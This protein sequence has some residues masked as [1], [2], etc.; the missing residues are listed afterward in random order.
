VWAEASVHVE[1]S[2]LSHA[3]LY[4]ERHTLILMHIHG[5]SRELATPV[6]AVLICWHIDLCR[7]MVRSRECEKGAG[8]LEALMASAAVAGN[9]VVVAATTDAWEAARH[10]FARLLGRGDPD[11][12][13]TAE[14]RLE[15]THEQLTNT[16]G[17]VLE[18][19]RAAVEVQWTTRLADLLDEYPEA[20]SDLRAL[21]AEI[22]AQ[23]PVGVVTA[24]D[25]AVAGGRDV[26]IMASGG[27][28]AAGVI[29]GDVNPL[30]PTGPDLAN[31]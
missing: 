4:A 23:L 30:D 22:R 14:R 21:V 27:G 26:N 25:H 19:I 11:K 2:S 10:K 9:T 13:K 29:H 18:R 15:E 16:T 17:A 31:G 1:L 8:M 3:C 7:A 24:T 12:T 20:E 5:S 28:V 6:F